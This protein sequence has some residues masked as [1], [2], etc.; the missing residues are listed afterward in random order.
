MH[1]LFYRADEL[2]ASSRGVVLTDEVSHQGYGLTIHFVMPGDVKV[3]LYQPRY[4]K[5]GVRVFW[6]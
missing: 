5:K 2:R 4:A 3:E 1:A 6:H